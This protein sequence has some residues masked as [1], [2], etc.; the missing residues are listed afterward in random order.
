M[1]LEEGTT[2]VLKD[3]QPNNIYGQYFFSGNSSFTS[4]EN[5][6]EL[7]ITRLDL[8][9]QIVSGTFFYDVIDGNGNLRQIRDG[10]FDMRFTQ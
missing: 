10:R 6:G 1:E 5:S 3:N 9:T 4:E 7:T 8:N 2:Y